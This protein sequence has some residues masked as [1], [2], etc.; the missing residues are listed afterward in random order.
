MQIFYKSDDS[1][2]IRETALSINTATQNNQDV[3]WLLSGGSAIKLA[4]ATASLLSDPARVTV[5]LVDERY[6]EVGH[7]DSNWQQ[8]IDNG[9]PFDFFVIQPVLIGK[10]IEET[11]EHFSDILH[12]DKTIIAL[13]G[14]GLDSHTSGILPESIAAYEQLEFAIGYQGPDYMRVS[15]TPAFLSQIDIGILYVSGAQKHAPLKSFL[16]QDDDP[17]KRPVQFLKTAT[18]LIVITDMENQ[19]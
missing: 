18:S 3:L 14:M 4:A 12:T 6:G 17:T 10:S 2:A 8:L 16:S 1:I 19:V 15:T 11:V 5:S 7:P 9:F 13:L